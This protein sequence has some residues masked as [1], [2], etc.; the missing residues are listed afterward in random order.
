MI[1]RFIEWL[2]DRKQIREAVRRLDE[3]EETIPWEQALRDLDVDQNEFTDRTTG[4]AG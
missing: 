1:S 3:G 4:T 2:I